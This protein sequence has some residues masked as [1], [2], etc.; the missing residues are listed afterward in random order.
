MPIISAKQNWRLVP[1]SNCSSPRDIIKCL[2][3]VASFEEAVHR[4]NL[5]R[6]ARSPGQMY[7]DT[8]SP[9]PLGPSM[10]LVQF[11]A[12]LISRQAWPLGQDDGSSTLHAFGFSS[13]YIQQMRIKFNNKLT[14]AS[15]PDA[16]VARYGSPSGLLGHRPTTASTKV[17]IYDEMLWSPLYATE[18]IGCVDRYPAKLSH[19]N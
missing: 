13:D 9:T 5:L 1:E 19:I 3:D 17:S 6:A 2:I 12:C 11:M 10:T 14:L 7:K 8:I 16:N 4:G 15:V 18:H